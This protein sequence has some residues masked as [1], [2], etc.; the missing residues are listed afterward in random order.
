MLPK[1]ALRFR[2]LQ[3]RNP[4]TGT[5][6]PVRKHLLRQKAVDR[7]L[8]DKLGQAPRP[9]NTMDAR[10]IQIPHKSKSRD[11]TC[12]KLMRGK[13]VGQETVKHI[14]FDLKRV[15]CNL[16]QRATK[17]GGKFLDPNGWNSHSLSSESSSDDEG[18]GSGGSLG[19]SPDN[20]VNTKKTLYFET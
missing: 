19:S 11:A 3:P 15:N 2:A 10:C 6:T 8:Y 14:K 12:V 4:V 9:V 1:L 17:I 16:S 18:I 5:D 7:S 13:L 20:V